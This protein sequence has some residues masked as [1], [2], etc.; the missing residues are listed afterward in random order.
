MPVAVRQD[1][2]ILAMLAFGLLIATMNLCV[3]L[4]AAYRLSPPEV[5]QKV[6]LNNIGMLACAL[7]APFLLTRGGSFL[8]PLPLLM[9]LTVVVFLGSN[10]PAWQDNPS[11]SNLRMICLGIFWP[12]ALQAFFQS[13]TPNRQGLLLGLLFAGGELIW[14]ARR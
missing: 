4:V 8:A 9:T 2:R 10:F 7:V 14:L 12:L 3:Y 1:Y 6:V 13:V 5:I 11:A